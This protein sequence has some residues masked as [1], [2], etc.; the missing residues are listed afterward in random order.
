[1][2]DIVLGGIMGMF[3][4]DV[5]MVI[6]MIDKYKGRIFLESNFFRNI[7]SDGNVKNGIL[8]SFNLYYIVR[9]LSFVLYM[10][11]IYILIRG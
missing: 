9:I 2:M 10:F 1:M 8:L 3:K 4:Y 11:Y 7:S 5:I 6:D